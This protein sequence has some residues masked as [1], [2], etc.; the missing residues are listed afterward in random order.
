MIVN[1]NDTKFYLILIRCD[2]RL[3]GI[4]GHLGAIRIKAFCTNI[5]SKHYFLK[6]FV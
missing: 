6:T 4:A 2:A 1:K 5:P 3:I